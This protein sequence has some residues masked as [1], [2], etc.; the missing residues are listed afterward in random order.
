MRILNAAQMR[1]ADRFTI[2]EI[3]IPSLVLMENAGRQVVAAIEAAYEARL[4]GRV[5][6]LCGRGNNGGDGFVVARTLLQRGIDASVFV[7][8]SL[9]QVRGDAKT[10]LDILGR[11]GVTVVEIGDEQ[12]WE[13]HFSEISQCTLIVDAIF[14]TG[15]KAA[16]GGMMETIV[17]DV[18]ASSLPIVSIDL[19]SGLS[20]DTP[21]VIGDCIDASMTVTLAAPKLPLVLPPGEEHAGDVVIAD[22]GIP[23]EVID[24]IEGQHIELLTPEQLRDV[25]EPR[26]ADSHKGDFGRVTIVAGSR[27]KTGAAHLAAMGALRSGAGLVTV[28]TP[29]SVLPIVA[30]MAPEL[31]T[32]PLPE[33]ADGSVAAKAIDQLLE[34]RHDVIACGS[35]IGRGPAV[36]AFVGA[37][38]ER[39]TVPLVLDADAITVLAEDPGRLTGREERDVIITPHPGEMARL[40]GASIE[41]VQGSR[42]DVATEFATTHRLYVVL[43]G[44]RTII[45]TPD[46]HIF[47]NP[48]GNAGMATGGT[49]DVLTGMIAAW[50]AQL[51]DAEAACRLAV[52]LH[53][54]AG[55][56]AEASEGQVAMVATDVIAHLGDAL[57]RLCNPDK[58]SS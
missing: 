28:A 35:G 38:L 49:G 42:I 8:G 53:G 26:A 3:G 17:A 39:A 20:A 52:F 55:D 31:M 37:L 2:E 12:S 23:H 47:I 9:T 4:N 27:G 57:N 30:S 45:A 43:K 16:L 54:A 58:D 51:L 24:G 22:I 46:G 36:G 32:E 13:L 15:L 25:V 29:A 33:E 7:I 21:H 14:G 50:L 5:A 48:T 41:E 11:L 6:V 44:H 40:I 1:E 34:L 10:N 18:N 19:P 56:L